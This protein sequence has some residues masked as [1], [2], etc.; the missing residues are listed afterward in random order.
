MIPDQ[1]VDLVVTGSNSA[2]W[3]FNGDGLYSETAKWDPTVLPGGA[4]STITFGN[5]TTN[6]VNVPT[7][8]VT[9]DAAYTAGNLVFSNT[10]GAAYILASGG[11]GTGIT[12]SNSGNGSTISVAAGVTAQQQIQANLTLGENVTFNLAGGTSLLV[13]GGS[14]SDNGG[15]RSLTLS[16]G[17][18]LTI[19]SASAYSGT[20]TIGAGTLRIGN[21]GT[22]G[23][24]GTGNV[25]DNATLSFNRS[26]ALAFTQVISG[27]GGLSQDG[28]GTTTLSGLNTFSGNI[29]VNAG[30]LLAQTAAAQNAGTQEA[31]GDATVAG[32]TITVNSG[33]T[34]T[35]GINN[36]FGNQT[37]TA[38]TATTLDGH[39][40]PSIIVN[41]GTLNSTCYN[42]VGNIMLDGGTMSQSATDT[43]NFEGYQFL[44]S[45]T[46][47]GSTPSTISTGNGKADHLGLNT[48]FDVADVTGD[49]NADLT[50]SAP[51]RNASNDYGLVAGSLN[52]TGAGTMALNAAN[53]YTGGTTITN[54][55]LMTT[56]VGTSRQ[57]PPHGQRR[58]R[59]QLGR[60]PWQQSIGDK[61]LRRRFRGHSPRECRCRNNADRQSSSRFDLCR[62][63]Q[64]DG[65]SDR[66]FRRHAHQI[67][68]RR[69]RAAR[70]SVAGQQWQYQ[71][72]RG[73][74]PVPCR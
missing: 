54:G 57:R 23:S 42:Q 34:L 7:A 19:D 45:V 28:A 22:T 14:I 49:A 58:R 60:E 55:T 10:N 74:A 24:L 32:R 17:G 53:V 2:S 66:E 41:G 11:T 50:V 39:L 20:T 44:G 67:G 70:R 73:H 15:G 48:L 40:L 30:T 6:A 5:G 37:N 61:P 12:L 1:E 13:T 65:W 16:G 26:N 35:F 31:L 36:V 27:T 51:L 33:A 3:N 46:V 18:T 25:V 72:Y 71:C 59:C 68:R 29:V 43:G 56:G 47:N 69:S 4:G 38:V 64:L 21:G 52:K 62:H 8:T 9:V 63:D